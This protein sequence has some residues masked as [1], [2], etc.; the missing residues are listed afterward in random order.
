MAGSTIWKSVVFICVTIAMFSGLFVFYQTEAGRSDMPVDASI[1]SSYT[2]LNAS[3][4]QLSTDT[5]GIRNSAVKIQ[6]A[7]GVVAVGIVTVTG[8]TSVMLLT[9]D[10]LDIALNILMSL[11]TSVTSAIGLPSWVLPL[12]IVL[13]TLFIIFAILRAVTGRYEI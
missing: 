4:A 1:A 2:S 8:F 12:V 11:Y 7:S 6:E 5:Q 13:I 3:I 10:M 9:G